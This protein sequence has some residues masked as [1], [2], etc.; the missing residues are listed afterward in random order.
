[1]AAAGHEILPHVKKISQKTASGF[2]SFYKPAYA[3]PCMNP[4]LFSE[5][6]Y[7]FCHRYALFLGMLSHRMA[8]GAV[9]SHEQIVIATRK[10]S[11]RGPKR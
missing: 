10:D 4:Y 1:M 7:S 11:Y 6:T 8:I 5:K 3:L 2:F 9:S